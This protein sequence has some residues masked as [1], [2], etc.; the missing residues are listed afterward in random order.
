MEQMK[1]MVPNV[2]M[3]GNALMVSSPA[4]SSAVYATEFDSASV[5]M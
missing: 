2:R 3:G 5:G 4:L 1:P